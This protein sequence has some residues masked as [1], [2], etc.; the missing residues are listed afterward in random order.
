MIAFVGFEGPDLRAFEPVLEALRDSRVGID[1]L[2]KEDIPRVE[3]TFPLPHL[4]SHASP[5]EHFRDPFARLCASFE[6]SAIDRI[7]TRLGERGSNLVVWCPG[8]SEGLLG[9]AAA[10]RAG[11][12]CV[13]LLPPFFEFKMVQP[14]SCLPHKPDEI[15]IAA[16]PL[17]EARFMSAGAPA[18]RIKALG[19][20]YFDRYHVEENWKAS[21]T[22]TEVLIPLQGEPG[23][24]G[25]VEQ[26]RE[27]LAAY[28]EVTL[29][30]REHPAFVPSGDLKL[31]ALPRAFERARA[32]VSRNS[33]VLFEAA[34]YGVPG[35]AWQNECVP[36]DVHAPA[37]SGVSI[38]RTQRELVDE[39]NRAFEVRSAEERGRLR[40]SAQG[41]LLSRF[42]GSARAIAETLTSI[43]KG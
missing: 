4:L 27:A 3:E 28:P 6:E 22:R 23:D 32:V 10:A 19:S 9:R 8:H 11:I 15:F 31:E 42:G 39:M 36:D 18:E 30:V 37:G 41:A 24:S 12:P 38:A 43:S 34:L 29:N 35:I 26:V 33:L 25:V 13:C 14:F 5:W 40:E 7:E 2:S 21:G 20:P 16:G 17:G 1:V